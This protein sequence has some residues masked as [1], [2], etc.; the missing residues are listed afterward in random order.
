MKKA[1]QLAVIAWAAELPV[2]A[3]AEDD[4]EVAGAAELDDGPADGVVLL[5]L[6]PQAA[7]VTPAAAQ[8]NSSNG[9]L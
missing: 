7:R 8:A 9:D 4:A 1:V 3:G 2:D 5:E 6:L